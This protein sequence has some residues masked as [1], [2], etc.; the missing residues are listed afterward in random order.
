[1]KESTMHQPRPIK[2]D[3]FQLDFATWRAHLA[4]PGSRFTSTPPAPSVI[5]RLDT[6][7]GRAP[8]IPERRIA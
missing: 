1:M 5:I 6:T 8:D 2:A 4:A 3:R 7:S